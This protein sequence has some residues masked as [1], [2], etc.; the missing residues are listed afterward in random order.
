MYV[1]FHFNTVKENNNWYEYE[2]VALQQA[3][4]GHS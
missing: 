3:I 2:Y 1:Y 4:I